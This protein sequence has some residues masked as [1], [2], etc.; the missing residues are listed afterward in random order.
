MDASS[1]PDF[2]YFE[3]INHTGADTIYPEIFDGSD[4]IIWD[5]RKAAGRWD[6]LPGESCKLY[7][8]RF[9]LIYYSGS[10][11]HVD[12]NRITNGPKTQNVVH[13]GCYIDGRSGAS[14]RQGQREEI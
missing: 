12:L 3:C 6:I 9:Y 4:N 1:S 5:G 13:L 11:V 2:R 14:N 7:M 10:K 8:G